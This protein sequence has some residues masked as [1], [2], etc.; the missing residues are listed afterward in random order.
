MDDDIMINFG[1]LAPKKIADPS[2]NESQAR[3]EK[4]KQKAFEQKTN[5]K[6]FLKRQREKQNDDGLEKGNVLKVKKPI[7]KNQDFKKKTN[8]T[9]P[10]LAEVT[11]CEENNPE[12]QAENKQENQQDS[13][14]QNK[15]KKDFKQY[16]EQ[17]QKGGDYDNEIQKIMHQELNNVE[18]TKQK[19]NIRRE[20]K[21]KNEEQE[22]I[23]EQK[24]QEM[25]QKVVYPFT[26]K[27][28]EEQ[29]LSVFTAEKFSELEQIHPKIVQALQESNYETMTK[30]QKEGIPQILKKENIALKSETG[31]GKTLTYLVPIISNLVHMGTDQK[32]TRE[33][34][35]YVFVICPTRELC[36][37]CEEVA[38][39][40]T[41]KSKYLITGCLM[42][43]ENPKKEKARLRKGVTILFATPGR[44][45]YHLK[46]TNSF[47]FSK[48]KYI[49]F[50]ESDR[51]LDMGFKKDLEEIVEQLT[52][53]VQFEEVQ[54]ILISANF[55]DSV[56]SLY[57]KMSTQTI[58][59]V[60]F[61]KQKR[62]KGDGPINHEEEKKQI[63]GD[64]MFKVPDTLIQYY[65]LLNEEHRVPFLVSYLSMLQETKSIIF[66]STCDEV[67]Y[68]AFLFEAMR[69]K[70]A[71]GEAQQEDQVLKQ[72]IFKLHGNIE[73]RTRSETYFQFKRYQGGAILIS[74]DVA[75]RG[76]DFYEVTHTI[77]FDVPTSISEYCNRIGRTARI[78]QKG[79]S[80]L[81]LNN[82]ERPYVDK[83]KKYGIKLNKFDDEPV[84]EKVQREIKQ[85]YDVGMDTMHYVESLIRQSIRDDKT[86]YILARRAY[87]SS[88]R[89]YARL[90]DKDIFRVKKLNLHLIAKG[91][92][93]SGVK[94]G[95]ETTSKQYQHELVEANKNRY[96]KM[97]K[98]FMERLE[99]T[100]PKRKAMNSKKLFNM[101]FM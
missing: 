80:L 3:R 68:F 9:M 27:D 44:L 47:L 6:N 92:G 15:Q 98:F 37:Q 95:N 97:E 84:L 16:L 64:D 26:E 52:K 32:I 83:M 1:D 49:V 57:L 45:L 89:A 22:Q 34:G 50:E 8:R 60:G 90:K 77:L 51:T 66:V 39:L 41:K 96:D 93:L 2:K 72:K 78:D 5:Y 23:K 56:E 81:I 55:N 28:Q 13:T 21:Q 58:K 82:V 38:Q 40:V 94:A 20:N 85:K 31:S 76:L 70:D 88:L 63:K 35:S 14:Q 24:Q 19:Q 61:A 10:K 101:E 54:K 11:C 59:Y 71:N 79:I 74:T 62:N 30:I 29:K 4:Y 7:S 99:K 43:G 46:N 100:T 67:D 87:V 48:L 25:M 53:K 42:G 75:S 36:I 69:Y 18:R 12:Q 73:Q 86:K 33:D 17:A 91:F 65:S